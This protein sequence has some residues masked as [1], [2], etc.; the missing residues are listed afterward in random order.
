MTL[1]L[2]NQLILDWLD[3]NG[4]TASSQWTTQDQLSTGTGAYAALATAAQACSH[5]A[6]VGIQLQTSLR[7]AATP[8]TGDYPT[9][10]DRCAL[11]AKIP[12]TGVPARQ[13][14]PGPISGLFLPDT[15]TANLASVQLVAL[16]AQIMALIGDK[17]GNPQGPFKRGFRRQVSL[18]P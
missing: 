16:E 4:A 11:L 15:V 10:L 13:E 7:I 18:V 8:T 3:L 6:L 1:V 9:V 14:I 2:Y 12:A 5:C 17:I